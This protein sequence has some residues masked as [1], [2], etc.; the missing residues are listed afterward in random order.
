MTR[1]KLAL[2]LAL[3]LT[4]IAPATAAV[5]AVSNPTAD[6]AIRKGV[7]DFVRLEAPGGRAK[8]ID[9][10]CRPVTKVGQKGACAG[11]FQVAYKGKTATYQLTSRAR[12]LRISRGAV[13]YRLAAKAT[14]KVAGLPARTDLAGFLQ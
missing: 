12:T 14:K 7:R 4:A 9:I 2:P 1:F 8:H 11:T 5:A 10:H 13:E 6:A 3:A